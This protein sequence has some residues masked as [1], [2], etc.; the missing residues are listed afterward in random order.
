M[1]KYLETS[2][3]NILFQNC[4]DLSLFEQNVPGISK[5]LPITWKNIFKVVGQ[6]NFQ[7]K[8]PMFK[9]YSEVLKK[10][11]CIGHFLLRQDK[12]FFVQFNISY[13]PIFTIHL[14]AVFTTTLFLQKV[15]CACIIGAY[16]NAY[17]SLSTRKSCWNLNLLRTR[18]Q[19]S[20][21]AIKST[22]KKSYNWVVQSHNGL[23]FFLNF[24]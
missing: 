8:I 12:F 9:W 24:T 19:C 1:R 11:I 2:Q 13:L 15:Y 23:L 10:I 21:L 7:N 22:K 17:D 18:Q 5:Y 3:K 16:D 4:S 14:L 6:N 20:F